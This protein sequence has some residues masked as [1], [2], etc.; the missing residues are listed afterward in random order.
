MRWFF[1]FGENGM[2]G[3]MRNLFERSPET[4]ASFMHMDLLYMLLYRLQQKIPKH[5]IMHN[6]ILWKKWMHFKRTSPHQSMRK[7]SINAFKSRYMEFSSYTNTNLDTFYKFIMA[8]LCSVNRLHG[9]HN[10][11]YQQVHC[12]IFT[13]FFGFPYIR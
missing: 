7:Y 12:T 1:M 13:F 3:W 5:R 10:E 2:C 6:I 4:S 8:L 11:E 9:E